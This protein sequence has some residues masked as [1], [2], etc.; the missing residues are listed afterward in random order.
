MNEVQPDSPEI[1]HLVQRARAGDRQAFEELFAGYRTYLRQFVELRMD[2]K[3]RARADPSDIVQ[4]AQLEAIRRLED[5]LAQPPMPFRL[6]LRQITFN[7]LLKMHRHHVKTARRAV[8]R[9]MPL[10]DQSSLLLAEQVLGAGST[11]SQQVNR[12]ELAGRLR[13]AMAQ[14][15]EADREI[16]LLRHFEGLSNPEVGQLLGLDPNTVSKRHG[17]AMLRLHQILFESGLTES[18]L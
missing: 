5:Y 11:P 17:R 10:P 8:G 15:A 12:R 16:L 9:E 3:L 2:P 14:L 18:Q 1:Q 7:R 6:W 4:E 13:Q